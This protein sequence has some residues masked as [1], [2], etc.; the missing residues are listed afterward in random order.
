MN[1]AQ[2][3]VTLV[4]MVLTSG[5]GWFFFHPQTATSAVE[6]DGMQHVR[7]VV[8]GGYSPAVVQAR[9][10]VPLRI[11]FDRQEDGD[12]SARVVFADLAQSAWLAPY[13][14][15]TVD[16]L[17]DRPGAFGFSCGMNMIHGTVLAEGEAPPASKTPG[18][19]ASLSEAEP[20]SRESTE[21]AEARGRRAHAPAGRRCPADPA[22]LR[23]GHG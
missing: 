5:L 16:V 9:T 1:S 22:G 19:A 14:E 15:T 4:G 17:L 12:C 13:A 23:G 10:G 21:Q 2:V 20:P 18:A 8:K 6:L 11:V 7:V 3:L